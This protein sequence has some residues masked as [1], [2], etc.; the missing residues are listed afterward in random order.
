MTA[1]E[2]R[3]GFRLFLRALFDVMFK[4]NKAFYVWMAF[5]TLCVFAGLGAYVSQMKAGLIVTRMRDQVSW[6]FYVANFTFMVGVAAAAVLLI[7]PAYLYSF[8]PIK[9]I[10]ILGE[11]LAVSAVFSALLFIFVDFGRA[12]RFW[13]AIPFIG[14]P[15]FPGSILAWDMVVLNGYLILNLSVALYVGYH[16][17]LGRD[18][19]KRV[20]LPLVLLSIP[21]AIGIH[22]VTA[23]VYNGLAARPFWNA[24][25]LAP[26]FLASA[27]CSGPALMIIIFQI[28]RKV[29]DFKIDDKAIMRISE[30]IAFAMAINIF[31]LF[32]EVY[33]EYYSNTVHTS[34][35][36]YLFLGLHGHAELV[37]WIWSAMF[38]NGIGFLLFLIPQT[39]KRLLTLN[40]GCG[41]I[42][43]GIWIEKGMGLV[44]P[45]FIPDTLGEVYEYLPNLTEA[46]IA[47]GIWALGAIMYTLSVR[48]AVAIETG[49]LRHP[50]APAIVHEEEGK[51]ARD[52]MS[53]KVISVKQETPI[54]EIGRLL[55]LHRISG[56]PVVDNASR[57]IGVV[58][59]SDIIFREID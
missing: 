22:T 12:E 32:A 46:R 9:K 33:K 41:L 38:F 10:V 51:L 13:H 40:I 25:I 30:I 28:L 20:V 31:L 19:D 29:T 2:T 44:L 17:Y 18:P 58:S 24:S 23:F 42:F 8:K 45:G 4:G 43:I 49:R 35:I 57:V 53:R 3:G 5:L 16:T 48:T 50:A 39:R 15:N 36:R 54:E 11:L 37:P 59:E 27:F 26:R 21:W 34:Q 1:K 7:I 55:V 52:V 14:T 6:G 56:V 47:G